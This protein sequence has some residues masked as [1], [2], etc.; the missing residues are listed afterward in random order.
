[1]LTLPL[2]CFFDP[3][4]PLIVTAGYASHPFIDCWNGGMQR[5]YPSRKFFTFVPK[6]MQFR[7][8]SAG[9]TLFFVAAVLGLVAF[10][11]TYLPALTSLSGASAR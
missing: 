10:I 4:I 5:F 9:D 8:G 7:V 3:F 11:F 6:C 2:G 1:M